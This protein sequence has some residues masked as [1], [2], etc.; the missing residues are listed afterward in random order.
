LPPD[1]HIYTRSKLPWVT[2]PPGAKAYD[3]FYP[4]P[5]EVWSPEART[6]WRTMLAG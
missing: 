6:R 1:V 4:D 3:G 5:A 2:L